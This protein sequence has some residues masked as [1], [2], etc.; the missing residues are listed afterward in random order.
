MSISPYDETLNEIQSFCEKILDD[1]N[2][3]R[4]EFNERQIQ[5]LEALNK[6]ISAIRLAKDEARAWTPGIQGAIE[7]VILYRKLLE[8]GG[9]INLLIT[10]SAESLNQ[11]V[12]EIK[13]G[14]GGRAI[15]AL[16]G[17]GLAVAGCVVSFISFFKSVLLMPSREVIGTYY[18]AED[19][20]TDAFKS[21][22]E[23]WSGKV[24]APELEKLSHEIETLKRKY[25][26]PVSSD[27][28]RPHAYPL[29]APKNVGSTPAPLDNK[30]PTSGT[31]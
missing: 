18:V 23:T 26:P 19:L 27:A 6:L 20:F 30:K 24:E 10:K 2:Q 17:L 9:D 16:Q 4:R 3:Q 21:F 14:A 7:V 15:S 1:Y 31:N 8:K 13:V 25:T 29:F 12:K 22:K 5:N 28:E 11:L